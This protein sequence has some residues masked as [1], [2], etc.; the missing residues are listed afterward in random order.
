MKSKFSLK[1]LREIKKDEFYRNTVL[2]MAASL[3]TSV[4]NYAFYP[5]MGRLI[6]VN[7]YGE[8][9]LVTSFLLQIT[10]LFIGLNLISVNIVVNHDESEVIELM[11]ALQKVVFWLIFVV[12]LVLVTVSSLLRDFFQFSSALPF[13]ILTIC[14]LVDA[15]AVFWTGYLQGKKD[16]RSLSVYTILTGLTK[17]IFSVILVW[18]GFGVA[19]GVLGI[20]LGLIFSLAVMRLITKHHLPSVRSTL[21]WP[22]KVEALLIKK[23]LSYILEVIIAL[24]VMTLLLSLDTLFV[25]HLFPPELAGQYA[26]IATIARILFYVSAPIV[27]VMLPAITLR[28]PESSKKTY[29]RTIVLTTVICTAGVI[30]ATLFPGQVTSVLL[31]DSFAGSANLLPRL[32]LLAALVAILNVVVNYLLAL[33]DKLALFVTMGGLATS[34]ILLGKYHSTIVDV[35]WSVSLG[36]VSSMVLYLLACVLR[37][38]RRNGLRNGTI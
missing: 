24:L 6:G 28:D 2:F 36:V 33:R 18:L 5:I 16:F 1:G 9:Q 29:L 25:K 22:S 4:L 7:E 13:I 14:L 8:L 38:Y 12:C 34:V 3:L 17:I 10:T 26:G 11:T 37:K 27:S 15:I 23:H 30:I 31:G 35:I 32:A 21:T 20:G 19:G